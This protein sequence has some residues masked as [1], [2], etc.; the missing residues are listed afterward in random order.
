MRMDPL[1]E[2]YF[3]FLSRKQWHKAK[4]LASNDAKSNKESLVFRL[5]AVGKVGAMVF[6][7]FLNDYCT[8]PWK[9]SYKSSYVSKEPICSFS[10]ELPPPIDTVRINV[11]TRALRNQDP[12]AKFSKYDRTIHLDRFPMMVSELEMSNVHD[13]YMCCGYNVTSREGYI[14][15][16]ATREEVLTE[17]INYDLKYP[18][19]CISIGSLHPIQYLLDY[20]SNTNKI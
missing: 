12:N 10:I 7:H 18:A 1:G 17:P 4:M 14:L 20:I 3:M 5:G 16:W 19:R 6:E 15:G 9:S 11:K 2:C 13:L 8:L